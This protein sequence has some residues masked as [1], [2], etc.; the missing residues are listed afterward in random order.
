[1]QLSIPDF[2]GIF[3]VV[4]IIIAYMLLQLEKIDAKDISFSS[5]NTLGSFLIILSLLYDW[6]FASFMMESTWMIL[7]LYGMLKYYSHKMSKK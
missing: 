2:I 4:I 7:S 1:M 5:L 3:G 6:N